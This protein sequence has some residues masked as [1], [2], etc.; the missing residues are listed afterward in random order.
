MR[1]RLRVPRIN[2]L[3]K[4]LAVQA[5]GVVVD[6]VSARFVPNV[7]MR[8]GVA[9]LAAGMGLWY[10]ITRMAL[11]ATKLDDAISRIGDG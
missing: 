5:T 7:W 3:G 6:Q 2:A 10:P 9:V 8:W 4:G 11:E 1:F